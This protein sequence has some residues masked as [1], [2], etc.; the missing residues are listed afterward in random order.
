[1]LECY[2]DVHDR[3]EKNLN[4]LCSIIAG[5]LGFDAP[6]P[7]LSSSCDTAESFGC[8]KRRY[9]SDGLGR[10]EELYSF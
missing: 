4:R 5:H 6:G 3:L 9:L 7:K 1:M 10:R 2:G 8:Y